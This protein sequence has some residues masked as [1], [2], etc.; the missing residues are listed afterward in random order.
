MLP[1]S[2]GSSLSS[3]FWRRRPLPEDSVLE[4]Q[5]S[6]LPR[7]SSS[8]PP[9]RFTAWLR[10]K[11][12]VA[13]RFDPRILSIDHCSVRPAV[14]EALTKLRDFQSNESFVNLRLHASFRQAVVI[15]VCSTGTFTSAFI[16]SQPCS[17]S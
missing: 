16:G 6:T 3:D 7:L 11:R 13:P 1:C 9:Q 5:R 8:L 2:T 15:M 14:Y 10:D 17:R 12:G 4:P